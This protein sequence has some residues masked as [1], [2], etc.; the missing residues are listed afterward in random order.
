M[1]NEYKCESRRGL[2]IR[3]S[4]A[5]LETKMKI[6]VLTALLACA[7]GTNTY[8]AEISNNILSF[9][10]YYTQLCLSVWYYLVCQLPSS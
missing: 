8:F 1:L 3:R 2:F 4:S 7:L 5:Y 9:W 6:I 10:M